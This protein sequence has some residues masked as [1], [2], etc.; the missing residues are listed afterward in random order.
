[1][2]AVSPL[3]GSIAEKKS[4]LPKRLR[5]SSCGS[6]KLVFLFF[7]A[8]NEPQTQEKVVSLRRK[9]KIN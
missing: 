2:A 3:F 9:S 7:F 4:F 5:F 8:Q 6:K 1:V